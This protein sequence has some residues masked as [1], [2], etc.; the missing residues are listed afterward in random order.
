MYT[1]GSATNAVT[2]QGAGVLIRVPGGQ[3]AAAGVATAKHS[4]N[5]RA[6]TEALV[7]APSVIQ[8]GRDRVI[9]SQTNSNN[10]NTHSGNVWETGMERIM[11]FPERVAATFNRSKLS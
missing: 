1:D 10:N 5:Y 8:E 3:T 4:A 6:E 2:T 9:V 7:Q 11:D